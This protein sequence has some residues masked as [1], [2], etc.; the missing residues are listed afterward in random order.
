MPGSPDWVQDHWKSPPLILAYSIVRPVLSPNTGLTGGFP[1]D[2]PLL[3]D[4]VADTTSRLERDALDRDI[5]QMLVEFIAPKSVILYQLLDASPD[6]LMVRRASYTVGQLQVRPRVPHDFAGLPKLSD[7]KEW[8]TCVEAKAPVHC[9]PGDDSFTVHFPVEDSAGA[10]GLLELELTDAMSAREVRLVEGFLR[11][12]RNQIALLDY[13]E[14]DTLTGLLNRKTFESQFA[15]LRS[16]L[17]EAEQSTSE[18]QS[19]LGMLDIDH[20]K[21]INDKFGHV[22]GDEVLLLISQI[23]QRS[24]RGGDHLFRFGGEEFV[25]V[26]ED[27]NA[28]GAHCVFERIRKAIESH[29][30]P[31]VV[32][33]TASLGFS[34]LRRRDV[35]EVC[36]ERADEALYFV[37][38]NGRNGVR[39]FEHLLESG[40]LLL[41]DTSGEI[42]LF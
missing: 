32:N 38:H 6:R 33:V 25:V 27:T 3:I 13:G 7:R 18:R 31:Q 23:V 1:L 15:K 2:E 19:W 30:F 12:L 17:P 4:R 37:K 36:V 11:I 24:L 14:R 22:I 40:D 42:E 9:P 28:A 5:V 41:K 10:T 39:C 29:C 26:L 20:F 34:A 35:P 16:E 8:L 21:S